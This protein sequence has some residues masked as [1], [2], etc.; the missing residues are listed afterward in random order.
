[1]LR[2]LTTAAAAA[3]LMCTPAMACSNQ[4]EQL[5]SQSQESDVYFRR[6]SNQPLVNE[7]TSIDAQ[8]CTANADGGF[9]CDTKVVNPVSPDNEYRN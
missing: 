8:N 5:V 4:S 6:K 1:M 2:S 9:T 7:Q 3:V